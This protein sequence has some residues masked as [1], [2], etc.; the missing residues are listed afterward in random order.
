MDMTELRWRFEL[1]VTAPLRQPP[2]VP[3]KLRP[4][5]VL[6]AFQAGP[7][8]LEVLLTQRPAHLKAH[9][10]QVSFPGGKQE[11][12][13]DTLLDTA[14]REAQ[15]EIGLP[16]DHVQLLGTLPE[17][18]TITGFN[19]TPVVGIVQQPFRP[20]LNPGEVSELFSL[21]LAFLLQPDCRHVITLQ[22]HQRRHPLTFIPYEG[23]LIW[24]ATAAIIDTFCDVIGAHDYRMTNRR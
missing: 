15:E 18:H 2:W 24:G 4:A 22:R 12:Q 17:H 16:P 9:P 23:R 3:Q 1:G 7:R 6:M 19:I 8:G 11:P 14:L 21:P 5:A 13:D 20:C 10:G